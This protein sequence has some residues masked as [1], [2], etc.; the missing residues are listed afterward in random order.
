MI[1][2]PFFLKI[3]LA[4]FY[5]YFCFVFY[6]YLLQYDLSIPDDNLYALSVDSCLVEGDPL[7]AGQ[8]LHRRH[9]RR[10]VRGGPQQRGQETAA[11]RPRQTR[12]QAERLQWYILHMLDRFRNGFTWSAVRMERTRAG[13][14]PAASW[15]LMF[16]YSPRQLPICN[17]VHKISVYNTVV[18]EHLVQA[19]L[20]H[21]LPALLGQ[22]EVDAEEADQAGVLAV[23]GP[24]HGLQQV[25]GQSRGSAKHRV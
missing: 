12:A 21:C 3:N 16:Q 8:L 14:D 4:N 24:H 19:A 2:F 1:K 7:R 10:P 11:T 5:E 18:M 25:L 22:G 6:V 20:L 23:P 13:S 17:I 9:G 15:R